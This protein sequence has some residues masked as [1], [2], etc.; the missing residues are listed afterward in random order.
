MAEALVNHYAGARWQAFSA[1]THPTGYVHPLALAALGEIGIEHAGRSKHV[2]EMRGETFDVVVA[3]CDA[4]A[5]ECP[6]WLGDGKVVRLPFPD[7]AAAVGTQ[8]EIFEF[9]CS[10]R[11][12]IASQVTALLQRF[13]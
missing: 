5:A 11:E 6:L 10:V 4:A 1:G 3:V 9:F 13:E 12:M 2:D 7:P 8:Q